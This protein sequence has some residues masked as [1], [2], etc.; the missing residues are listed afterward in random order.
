MDSA[1]IGC[2]MY[3]LGCSIKT[4]TAMFTLDETIMV[5]AIEAIF[6]GCIRLN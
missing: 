2:R 5:G 3:R 4:L 6:V 1:V